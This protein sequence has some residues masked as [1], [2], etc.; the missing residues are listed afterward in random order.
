M[1]CDFQQCAI[2]TSVDSDEPVQRLVSRIFKRQAT[3]L[4]RLRI[5][6]GWS[7]PLLVAH[8]TS[9][10][11]L[12][13]RLIYFNTKRDQVLQQTLFLPV[14]P[15]FSFNTFDK[16]NNIW[17]LFLDKL[18]LWKLHRYTYNL[19]YHTKQRTIHLKS[20]S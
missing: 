1:S 10:G 3:A 13:S 17:T 15:V 4:I 2:M 9:F 16:V 12:K 5:C 18:S 8:I 14:W 20:K 11:N 19:R 6:A 7:E